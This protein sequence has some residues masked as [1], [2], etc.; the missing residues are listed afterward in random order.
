[1]EAMVQLAGVRRMVDM[2]HVSCFSECLS[3]SDLMS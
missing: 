3:Y 2:L 1:M